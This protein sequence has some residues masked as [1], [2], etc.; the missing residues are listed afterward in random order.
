MLAH[1]H[2]SGD[3]KPSREDV[4]MTRRLVDA[5]RVVG[6]PVLD[7]V[8]IGRGAFPPPYVGLRDAGAVQF[9]G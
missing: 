3:P 2:P 8:I 6:I 7:H 1:N 9:D 4:R 5:G